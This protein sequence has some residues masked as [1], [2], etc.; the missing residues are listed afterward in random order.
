MITKLALF[1]TQPAP[2]AEQSLLTCCGSKTWARTLVANRSYPT[3]EALIK[4]STKL[5]FT[6]SEADWLEAFAHHPRIGETRSP[7]T[8]FLTHSESEQSATQQT[9]SNIADSL[10]DLNRAYEQ[11]FGF[12]YIVFASG[13][14]APELLDLL[15]SRMLNTRTEE[16]HEAALQQNRITSLRLE[17]W[18]QS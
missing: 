6:L 2:E 14:T 17:R 18:L 11:K 9:I 1:N 8:A 3:A 7:T 12:I 10:A 16:L 5:W 4:A 15:K 13:R